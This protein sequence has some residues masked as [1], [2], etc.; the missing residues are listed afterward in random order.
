MRYAFLCC[1]LLLAACGSAPHMT[2]SPLLRTPLYQV[3]GAG[4]RTR[5]SP[6]ALTPFQ[7]LIRSR[8]PAIRVPARGLFKKPEAPAPGIEEIYALEVDQPQGAGTEGAYLAIFR[9]AKGAEFRYF[10]QVNHRPREDRYFHRPLAPAELEELTSFLA[11]HPLTSRTPDGVGDPGSS[12]L[13][14]VESPGAAAPTQAESP[15]TQ[16]E[17][18]PSPTLQFRFTDAQ[19]REASM[20][21]VGD[22][23][24]EDHPAIDLFRMFARFRDAGPPAVAPLVCSYFQPIP[25]TAS[26][27]YASPRHE[28]VSVWC[29]PADD[30]DL[31]ILLS[32]PVESPAGGAAVGAAAAGG[33]R[34]AD[35]EEGAS[36]TPAIEARWYTRRSGDWL[37]TDSPPAV[38]QPRSS[39]VIESGSASSQPASSSPISPLP[40]R[41]M[42]A[43]EPGLH[44]TNLWHYLPIDAFHGQWLGFAIPNLT[45]SDEQ[46]VMDPSGT[47]VYLI[48]DGQLLSLPVPRSALAI[49]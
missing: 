22:P 46:F 15:P 30:G 41:E 42:W 28:V 3:S 7:I 21:V 2:A 14:P 44:S 48:F 39:P 9:S 11:A 49:K 6:A 5:V 26:I 33:L 1:A 40:T 38:G 29:N 8:L 10:E 43:A 20:F 35:D 45:F 4:A 19:L 34:T 31:R 47:L 13:V 36:D 18:P 23:S 17:E 27:V 25:S 24:E 37:P 16:A 32:P 12:A